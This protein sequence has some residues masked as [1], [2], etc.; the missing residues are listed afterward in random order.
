MREKNR[1]SNGAEVNI[2]MIMIKEEDGEDDEDNDDTDDDESSLRTMARTM[3]K[4]TQFNSAKVNI[5]MILTKEDRGRMVKMKTKNMIIWWQFNGAK[6]TEFEENTYLD[7]CRYIV[8][9]VRIY[10]YKTT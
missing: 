3:T 10:K 7:C 9:K 1:R 5:I 2:V 4:K 6:N 8:L